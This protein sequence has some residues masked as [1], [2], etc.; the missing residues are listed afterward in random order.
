MQVSL[1]TEPAVVIT[2]PH[3]QRAIHQSAWIGVFR[4]TAA[5]GSPPNRPARQQTAKPDLGEPTIAAG[6]HWVRGLLAA[7]SGDPARAVSEMDAFKRFLRS[8]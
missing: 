3:T 4:L 1:A 2:N 5:G 8:T 6:A 7:D